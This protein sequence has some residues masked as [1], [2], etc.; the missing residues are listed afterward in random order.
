MEGDSMEPNTYGRDPENV[1][2]VVVRGAAGDGA[3]KLYLK[4]IP[5]AIQTWNIQMYQIQGDDLLVHVRAEVRYPMEIAMAATQH[6]QDAIRTKGFAPGGKGAEK[7][8]LPL[9]LGRRGDSTVL[10]SIV[11]KPGPENNLAVLPTGRVI[12]IR[13]P[14]LHMTIRFDEIDVQSQLRPMMITSTV[15][16]EIHLTYLRKQSIEERT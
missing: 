13:G 2:F 5:Q 6:I 16:L 4:D 7:K 11:V 9:S 3:Y 14:H 15:T 8:V 12:T 1:E 10:T